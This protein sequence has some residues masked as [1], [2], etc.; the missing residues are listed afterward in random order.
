MYDKELINSDV[1]VKCGACCSTYVDRETGEPLS[2]HDARSSKTAELIHCPQ[3]DT[4]EGLFRCKIYQE[5]P[6]T[7]RE[8]DCL[9]RGNRLNLPYGKDSVL[10]SRI[11]E[12]V[13]KVH[14]KNISIELVD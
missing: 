7:C 9:E 2:L 12:A 14:G 1:C 4:S 13:G 6:A 8:W 3:L 5:R 11:R 10:G